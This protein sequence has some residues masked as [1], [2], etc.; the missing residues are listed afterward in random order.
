MNRLDRVLSRIEAVVILLCYATLIVLVG[1]ETVRRVITGNQ[2][3]WGPEIALYAF[4]WLCWFS[5]AE[6]IRHGTNLAFRPIRQRLGARSQL[7][8]E[9]LDNALWLLIGITIMVMSI[10]IVSN[11]IAMGQTVFGT[12]IPKAAATLAVPVGWGFSMIRVL[13]RIYALLQEH[14]AKQARSVA[15]MEPT[16]VSTTAVQRSRP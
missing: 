5:M 15:H 9:L 6:H 11:N 13:Q 7:G 12:S 14:G 16:P 2:V 4:I 3:I 8:L 10:D 1:E